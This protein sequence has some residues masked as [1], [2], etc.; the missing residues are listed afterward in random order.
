M[1]SNN[2]STKNH[3]YESFGGIIL[4]SLSA[5][6]LL[7]G[8]LF[9]GTTFYYY[10]QIKHGNGGVLFEKLYGGFSSDVKNN[11][12]VSKL[13]AEEIK[14]LESSDAPFLGNAGAK[15]TIVEF[16]DLKCPYTKSEESVLREV[17]QK[18]GSK[19]KLVVK[20]FPVESTHPG[21]NQLSLFAM[22]ANEQNYYWPVHDW[23]FENQSILGENQTD[24]DI[25]NL[26]E[27]FGLDVEKIRSCMAGID[28]KTLVNKDYSDGYRVGI[29]GTPTFFINGEKV[30]GVV[31]F[32]AWDAFLKNVK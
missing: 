28:I 9:G 7:G 1:D 26:A 22:C 29:E 19:V 14:N 21:S 20:H 10:W 32:S 12:T 25:K 8:L 3:W 27:H 16:I 17:L 5:F 30:Q 23:L 6:V 18:Y 4:V 2:I 31:P 13:S 15:I 24:N 11:N